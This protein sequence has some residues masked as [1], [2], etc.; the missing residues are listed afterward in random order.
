MNEDIVTRLSDEAFKAKHMGLITI[1]NVMHDAIYEIETLQH[2]VE[3]LTGLLERTYRI[4]V[5]HGPNFDVFDSWEDAI[6]S[7]ERNY[8]D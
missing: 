7:Y 3:R 6:A 4:A 2:E 5:G 8:H 1:R